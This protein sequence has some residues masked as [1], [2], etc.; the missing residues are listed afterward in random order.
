MKL[1][2]YTSVSFETDCRPR[3]TVWKPWSAPRATACW[4]L[5]NSGRVTAKTWR[6]VLSVYRDSSSV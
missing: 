2:Q 1:S 6:T 5:S 4:L 3:H